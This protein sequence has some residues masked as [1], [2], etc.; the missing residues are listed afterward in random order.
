MWQVLFLTTFDLCNEHDVTYYPNLCAYIYDPLCILPLA[1]FQVPKRGG[2][3]IVH[4]NVS[5]I[6]A[7]PFVRLVVTVRMKE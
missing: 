5:Y 2:H 7:R 4:G 1:T 6:W 3:G